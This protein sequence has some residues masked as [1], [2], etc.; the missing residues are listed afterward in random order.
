MVGVVYGR[1]HPL[2]RSPALYICKEGGPRCS[3]PILPGMRAGAAA[4]GCCGWNTRRLLLPFPAFGGLCL[5]RRGGGELSCKK[6]NDR[7]MLEDLQDFQR[8]CFV[9]GQSLCTMIVLGRRRSN[10]GLVFKVLSA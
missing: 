10:G 8:H 4:T 5:E 6:M 1:L 9:R 7:L 2:S 3:S